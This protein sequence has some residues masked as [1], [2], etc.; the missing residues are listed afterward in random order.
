[1][2]A[3]ETLSDIESNIPGVFFVRVQAD[4]GET[5]Q[6]PFPIGAAFVQANRADAASDSVTVTYTYA[7]TLITFELV[8]T[9]TGVNCS[10]MIVKA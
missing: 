4:D 5:Y 2:P 7:E 1:M 10:L 8:G 3:V 6:A 9:T